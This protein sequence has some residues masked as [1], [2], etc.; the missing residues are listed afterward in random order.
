M[1]FVDLTTS[2][3]RKEKAMET[4]IRQKLLELKEEVEKM[5]ALREKIQKDYSQNEAKKALSCVDAT[6]KKTVADIAD[7][8]IKLLRGDEDAY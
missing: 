1:G 3:Q 2:P 5:R 8:E 7:L 4:T 6:I